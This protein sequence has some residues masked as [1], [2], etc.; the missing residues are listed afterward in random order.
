V[1]RDAEAMEQLPPAER[2]ECRSLWLEVET[3]AQFV[4]GK[5]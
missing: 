2:D 4:D 1:L 3:L 5:E